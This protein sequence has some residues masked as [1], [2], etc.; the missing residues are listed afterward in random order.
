MLRLHIKRQCVDFR[1]KVR[2]QGRVNGPVPG[3]AALAL[4]GGRAQ[5]YVE[6]AFPAAIVARMA[7]MARAVVAHFDQAGLEG[8][9]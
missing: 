3:D 8:R 4:E 7:G 6:M 2:P 1:H 5:H 9:L